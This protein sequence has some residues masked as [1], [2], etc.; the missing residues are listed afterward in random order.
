MA[1]HNGIGTIKNVFNVLQD[2]ISTVKEFVLL[3]LTI[4]LLGP[5]VSA[6]DAIK[7]M[8]LIM[9]FVSLQDPLNQLISDVEPGI[10][11]IKFAFNAHSDM[12]QPMENANK[13]Q[14]NASLMIN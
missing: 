4:V 11:T 14:L 9:E 7:D 8:D 10:G 3:F 12:S 1:A 6:L 13:P 2:G 5:M